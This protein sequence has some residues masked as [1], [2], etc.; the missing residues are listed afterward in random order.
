MTG[1]DLSVYPAPLASVPKDYW[2]DHLS[3]NLIYYCMAI[4]IAKKKK[5]TLILY[6]V[7]MS[8]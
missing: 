6:N 1:Y 8:K 4:I 5:K 7:N 2:G 3:S